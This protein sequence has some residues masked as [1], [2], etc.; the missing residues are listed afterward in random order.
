MQMIIDKVKH[1]IEKHQLLERGDK[2][3]VAIS[4][5]P[6]SVCLLHILHSLSVEYGIKIYGA[7]LN[8]NFRGIEAQ[9]DAQYVN[10]LCEEL[11]IMPFVKSMDV[12]KYAK[13]KGYSLEEAG[14][15][16]RYQ[17]FDEVAEKVG[18]SKIAV[19][20][21][22]NDQAETVLMR[23]L[24]GAGPQGLAAIRHKRDK[25]IRPLLDATRGEIE[26]YCDM[27]NLAP[28][29]DHTNAQAIYH[30]NK[31]RLE[32]LPYLQKE[33]NPN[34]IEALVKTAS[35][36]KMDNDFLELQA[37]D[38]YNLLKRNENECL[39]LPILGINKLHLSLKSRILRIA[40]EE[41]LGKKEALE[42]KHINSILELIENSETGK[43]LVLP[44][45]LFVS[46]SYN[47]LIFSLRDYSVD[48]SFYYLLNVDDCTY[49]PEA[50]GEFHL[51]LLEREELKEI[52]KG[53]NIK[54]FDWDKVKNQLIVRNRRD[55]DRFI[56]L[57]LSGHKKLK[58]FFIDLKI[59]R[60]H[61][62]NIPLV[63]DGEEIMWIVGYRI[64]DTYKV[65]KN[66]ESVLLIEFR[67]N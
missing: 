40:A 55:G 35:L 11:D 37:R 62:D 25:I 18:A 47:Q 27:H 17:F 36:L 60:A 56:P 13:E 22:Q 31:I 43:R 10:N 64:S 29:I 8:H 44:E 24:R 34:I 14:R 46:K 6:D 66:T 48:N 42:Y 57:G 32:L 61:R 9:K 50:E 67:K 39:Y 2:L 58:D 4:G 1:A 59:E 21:N 49:I 15:I 41:L 65:T 45:G 3:V 51:R 20:H 23:L 19:A 7:H 26:A 53:N 5:G 52:P 12:G 28:R 63:C 30:R 38:S 33:Y 54:A 16:L